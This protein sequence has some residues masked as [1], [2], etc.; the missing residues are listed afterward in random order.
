VCVTHTS[1]TPLRQEPWLLPTGELCTERVSVC[2]SAGNA[3]VQV[4]KGFFSTRASLREAPVRRCNLQRPVF[5]GQ[6]AATSQ[7][8]HSRKRS[9]RVQAVLY[10]CVKASGPHRSRHV[11]K[12]FVV[13]H[14]RK[15]AATGASTCS[16]AQRIEEGRSWT[17][18]IPLET[19]R[20]HAMPEPN[21][22]TQRAH[23]LV[24][25]PTYAWSHV[26]QNAGA[27]HVARG[28]RGC[29]YALVRAGMA[30]KLREV[31]D[32]SRVRVWVWCLE[33]NEL[34]SRLL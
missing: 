26:R 30:C 15:T 2:V 1:A 7:V 31:T 32:S 23:I 24:R 3:N 27:T 12:R 25:R 16:H 17:G 14:N 8:E 5:S 28:W 18:S 10:T 11:H 22:D 34:S 29:A 33:T 20:A 9:G 21:S 4:H 19:P 13:C 6:T